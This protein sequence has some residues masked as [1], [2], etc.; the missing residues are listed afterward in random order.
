MLIND[1]GFPLKSK[2]F[3]LKSSPSCSVTLVNA[4][5]R[6]VASSGIFFS[7][8]PFVRTDG[9]MNSILVILLNPGYVIIADT[10]CTSGLTMSSLGKALI[11]AS[12]DFNPL[13]V[14]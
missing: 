1:L 12:V 11:I 4:S 5:C 10:V 8:L 9:I 7:P 3:R 14:T 13:P 6:S 2:T